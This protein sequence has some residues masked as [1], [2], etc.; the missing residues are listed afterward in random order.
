MSQ[1]AKDDRAILEARARDLAREPVAP[2]SA[3]EEWLVFRLGAER[4]A[5]G[6]RWVQE[7]VRTMHVAPLPGAAPPVNAI[8]AWR[9]SLIPMIDLH[10]L[11]GV[12]TEAGEDAAGALRRIIVLGH[13]LARCG[14][15]V[16]EVAGMESQGTSGV[17]APEAGVSRRGEYVEGVTRDA[18]LVV[19]AERLLGLEL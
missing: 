9:G 8:A 10:T 7:I 13:G 17:Q 11:L 3:R 12:A 15:R 5:F 6:A 2:V 19:S 1:T 16:D 14:V 4:C 18:V